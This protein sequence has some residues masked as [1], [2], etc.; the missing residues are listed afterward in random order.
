VAGWA[1]RWLTAVGTLLHSVSS[2]QGNFKA[3]SVLKLG[4]GQRCDLLKLGRP[5]IVARIRGKLI[6]KR[7][8]ASS[9]AGGN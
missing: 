7:A 5:S 3:S 8:R 4:V 9:I 6:S 2:P 1:P